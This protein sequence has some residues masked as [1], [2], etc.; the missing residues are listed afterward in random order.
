[1]NEYCENLISN[2]VPSW[3]VEE[4]YKFTI[5]PLKSTE[6]LVG[7]DKENSEL[8]RNVIIA[9]YIEGASATLEKCKDIMA[10][11]NIVRQWNEATGGYS[12]RF[13]GGDIFL[14]LVKADGI[15]ELRNP[16]GYGVQV[17]KCKDLDE[18]DA[19]AKE[20]LEAFL[21]TKLT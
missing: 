19:K 3:I 14:R 20:V 15:Y 16:I 13:K 8:Y 17:V 2:G 11:R 18:A 1:M 9:A 21:K 10:V 6:G 7:I 12:Y 5:E 4:A